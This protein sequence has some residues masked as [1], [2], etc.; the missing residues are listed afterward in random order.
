VAILSELRTALRGRQCRAYSNDL[1]IRTSE[2]GPYFYP[3]ASVVCGELRTADDH[4][5]TAL[6]PILVVEVISKSTE[7]FDRGDKFAYY[8]RIESLKEYVL[9]AQSK[10]HVEV[11]LQNG[12]GKWILSVFSGMDTVCRFESIGCEI[13]L[14]A[15]YGDVS[16][17]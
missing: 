3:D 7:A 16:L 11:F 9:I 13:P 4:R 10:P 1:R 6:N 15:I 14:S 5:D 2:Q 8:R 17:D 12:N